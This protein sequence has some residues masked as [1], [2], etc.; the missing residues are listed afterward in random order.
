M[1]QKQAPPKRQLR[2]QFFRQWREKLELTQDRALERLDGWTQSKLSRVETGRIVWNAYDLADLE[3]AY[4]V[5]SDLLLNVD[6]TKEGDVVDLMRII[7]DKDMDVIRAIV[8]GLPP[9]TGTH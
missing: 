2:R 3:A 7:R 9:K 6:P 4:G 1:A 5:S 8:E